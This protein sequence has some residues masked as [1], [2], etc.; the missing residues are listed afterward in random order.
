MDFLDFSLPQKDNKP[1]KNSDDL[2]TFWGKGNF[3]LP[4][5]LGKR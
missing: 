3:H 4:I 1:S 5:A 2:L